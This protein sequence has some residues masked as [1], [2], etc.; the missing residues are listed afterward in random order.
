[1]FSTAGLASAAL[2]VTTSDMVVSAI[3]APW[4]LRIE[5]DAITRF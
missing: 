4:R 2:D 3:F 1:L 5:R